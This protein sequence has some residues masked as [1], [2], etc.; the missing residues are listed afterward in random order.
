MKKIM[1]NSKPLQDLM[2]GSGVSPAA[3]GEIPAHCKNEQGVAL[4][5]A[6]AMLALLGMLGSFA[7]STS[8]TEMRISGNYRTV[9]SAF[10]SADLG[11]EYLNSRLELYPAN[12][13]VPAGLGNCPNNDQYNTIVVGTQTAC[14]KAATRDAKP[15]TGSGTASEM[16]GG[17][18]AT[19]LALT[20]IG[21][22]PNNTEVVVEALVIKL[23]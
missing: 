21:Y 13:S 1:E 16:G 2:V 18:N 11:L 23:N 4:V 17:P 12:S 7:L 20:V 22:G 9:Q 8:T 15:G 6:L 5:L 10:Y 19:A 3:T 14:Y